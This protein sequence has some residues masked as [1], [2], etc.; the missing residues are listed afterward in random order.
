ML[1]ITFD[2]FRH[3]IFFNDLKP[4]LYLG[5]LGILT[6][7]MNQ[8]LI[9]DPRDRDCIPITLISSNLPNSNEFDWIKSNDSSSSELI[10][11]LTDDTDED[12]PFDFSHQFCTS[13][14]NLKEVL[15]LPSLGYLYSHLI[16]LPNQSKLILFFDSPTANHFLVRDFSLSNINPALFPT[17]EDCSWFSEGYSQ[18]LA[19]SISESEKFFDFEISSFDV[20]KYQSETVP[21]I[22]SPW[23]VEL[24]TDYIKFEPS[25]FDFCNAIVFEIVENSIV[26]VDDVSD[27]LTC[28]ELVFDL[29]EVVDTVASLVDDVE[30]A[31]FENYT[32]NYISKPATP[33]DS[34][35][36]HAF[37]STLTKPDDSSSYYTD[38]VHRH[39]IL[40]NEL[41]SYSDCLIENLF[42]LESFEPTV[43]HLIDLE[44]EAVDISN[45][46][47][48]INALKSPKRSSS[49]HSMRSSPSA[50]K[51]KLSTP[52]PSTP[53]DT[54]EVN[55]QQNTAITTV[56]SESL[57]VHSNDVKE[58][59]ITRSVLHRL[60]SLY[61]QKSSEDDV[62]NGGGEM[63]NQHLNSTVEFQIDGQLFAIPLTLAEKCLI[64]DGASQ[65]RIKLPTLDCSTF[66]LIVHYLEKIEKSTLLDLTVNDQD[67]MEL[68]AGA[69]I[70]KIP[71]LLLLG[72]DQLLVMG[73]E[74]SF[75]INKYSNSFF[76]DLPLFQWF[77]L[78][79]DFIS[80]I[81]DVF[82]YL[83]CRS[84]FPTHYNSIN[85]SSQEN[86]WL[87]TYASISC[88][89]LLI[90]YQFDVSHFKLVGRYVYKLELCNLLNEDI[91]L[92]ASEHFSNLREL[93]V[94]GS[95]IDSNSIPLL[96]K[97]EKLTQL[98]LCLTELNS[99]DVQKLR[100]QKS[101]LQIFI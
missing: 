2:W 50:S 77:S 28:E 78:Q 45:E 62:I 20:T 61:K 49:H 15:N 53:D 34:N 16:T 5:Y 57:E 4:G 70:L 101:N 64:C 14:T 93:D 98:N 84:E 32:I 72:L 86:H 9:V 79:K 97:F 83:R 44:S 3:S 48:R 94:S 52:R 87:S 21:D 37:V 95:K 6:G 26:D 85:Y 67:V 1:S 75:I 11:P 22:N 36:D 13:I 8:Q 80:P 24:M 39:L 68:L 41:L 40:F 12:E 71:E 66:E 88:Q 19:S 54:P 18:L 81:F 51:E 17:T 65:S 91:L 38:E 58:A 76:L 55:T 25:V 10:E 47:K 74:I 46:R 35:I 99:N 27:I 92:V 33:H 30:L 59:R 100:D 42:D 63:E 96:Q 29:I 82:Y 89:S 69:E 7:V 31:C 60:G 56:S 43:R 73:I 90:N 23:S